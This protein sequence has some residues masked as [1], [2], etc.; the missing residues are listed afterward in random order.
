[1]LKVI[2]FCSGAYFCTLDQWLVDSFQNS[3][4]CSNTWK[5]VFNPL[6]LFFLGMYLLALK[7]R[8]FACSHKKNDLSLVT[9]VVTL[10][11]RHSRTLVFKKAWTL[12]I[13]SEVWRSQAGIRKLLLVSFTE[14]MCIQCKLAHMSPL[15][16]MQAWMF[17]ASRT[18]SST[19]RTF[20][21]VTCM[22]RL[23]VCPHKWSCASQLASCTHRLSAAK[24]MQHVVIALFLIC[25]TKFEIWTNINILSG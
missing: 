9:W 23:H 8:F 14:V 24:H 19:Y 16:G 15:V 5:R 2:T 11:V 21:D 10:V 7:T 20:H 25:S 4:H 1:M 3:R 18:Q 13:S 12:H 6:P 22:E 17:H